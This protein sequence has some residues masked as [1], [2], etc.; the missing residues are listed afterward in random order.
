MCGDVVSSPYLNITAY[1]WSIQTAACIADVLCVKCKLEQ[2]PYM[3][4]LELRLMPVWPAWPSM[5][6]TNPANG[7]E[8]GTSF[9]GLCT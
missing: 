5:V 1:N 4:C 8:L 2:H 7:K 3:Q 9:T 6:H